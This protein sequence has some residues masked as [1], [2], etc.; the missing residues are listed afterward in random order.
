MKE[1]NLNFMFRAHL[2]M[3]K[4]IRNDEPLCPFMETE[5]AHSLSFSVSGRVSFLDMS[6]EVI[7]FSSTCF[8][9]Q[10]IFFFN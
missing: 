2:H 3:L 1:M 8:F 6:I 5:T 4:S 9:L 7:F 10:R